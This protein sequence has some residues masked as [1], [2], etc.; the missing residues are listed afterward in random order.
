MSSFDAS[1]SHWPRDRTRYSASSFIDCRI[2]PNY[3]AGASAVLAA[4]SPR[5]ASPFS[6]CGP[7][8]LSQL[9]NRLTNLPM[10]PFLPYI[11]HVTTVLSPLGLNVKSTV[12]VP[13]MGRFQSIRQRTSSPGL[14]STIVELPAPTSL[15]PSHAH[16][17]PTPDSGPL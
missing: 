16:T 9:I 14:L 8:I 11:A 3:F 5:L 7:H 17:A 10:K 12:A 15:L 6:N 4:T 1:L 2:I 13:S